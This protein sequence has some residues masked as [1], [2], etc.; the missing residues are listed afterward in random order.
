M[1]TILAGG[2]GGLL[3]KAEFWVGV[4][5]FGFVGLLLWYNVPALIGKA[6]D[7]RADRIRQELDEA[8]RLRE[9]AQELLADYQR[10]RE[11]AEEEAK[12]IVEQ[13][14]READA[15]TS[16]TRKGLIES[17]ERRSK[18]AEEKIARAEAQAL[19]EVR[20]VAVDTAVAAAER[21]LASKVSAQAG[22]PLVD[23]SIRGLRGKLN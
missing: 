8:R 6:L 9:E 2:S 13:A 23:Q 7:E 20:S 10:K 18:I 16:E 19:A 3:M 5:F 17:L 1:L 15:L 12:A 21:V 11:A 14:R 4:S 22:A